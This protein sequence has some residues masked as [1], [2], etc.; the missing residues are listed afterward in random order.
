[1]K[2]RSS[3]KYAKR[4]ILVKIFVASECLSL[5]TYSIIVF[6]YLFTLMQNII[7]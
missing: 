6:I 4:A 7:R 5:A 1:M 3:L 2:L